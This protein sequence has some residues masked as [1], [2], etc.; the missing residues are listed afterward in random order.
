MP[1]FAAN[2]QQGAGDM[3]GVVFTEFMDMVEES[4]GMEMVDRIIAKSDLS[5]DGAYSAVGTYDHRELVRLVMS[6]SAETG[7]PV[8][9]L[10]RAYGEHLFIRFSKRYPVFFQKPRSSFEFLNSVEH[11][12]HVE[13]RKLYPDAELPRFRCEID[14]PRMTMLYESNHA[15]ADLAHGLIAGCARYYSEDIRIERE[16]LEGN[17][18]RVRFD[19]TKIG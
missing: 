8:P 9:D 6:L 16:N 5:T 17:G 2:R 14:G 10:L 11:T 3:K 12:V 13:V 1:R 4:F 7:T 19:L 15:F 18:T